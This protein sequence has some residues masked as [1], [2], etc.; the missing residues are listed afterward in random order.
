MCVSRAEVGRRDQESFVFLPPRLH[1]LPE[2]LFAKEVQKRHRFLKLGLLLVVCCQEVLALYQRGRFHSPHV[3][4][5]LTEVC[6]CCWQHG[7]LDL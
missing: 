4:E 6:Q 3:K 5:A 1:H 7:S 2:Y